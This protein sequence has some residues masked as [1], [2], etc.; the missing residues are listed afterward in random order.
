MNSFLSKK[1]YVVNNIEIKNY[2]N[3][4]GIVTTPNFYVISQILLIIVEVARVCKSVQSPK[5]IYSFYFFFLNY[6]L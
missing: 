2:R 5:F 3:D 6:N 4:I 1:I